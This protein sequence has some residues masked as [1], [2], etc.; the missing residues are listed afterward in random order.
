MSSC[1][2]LNSNLLSGRVPATVGGRLLY[3]AKWLVFGDHNTKLFH[4][5]TIIQRRKNKVE[6]IQKDDGSWV[7]NPNELKEL[8]VCCYKFFFRT[9]FINLLCY[10]VVSISDVA[11]SKEILVTI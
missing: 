11:S 6:T 10:R 8:V 5:T 9:W 4:S 1:R 2:N 7:S 3:R